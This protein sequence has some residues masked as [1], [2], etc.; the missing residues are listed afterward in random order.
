MDDATVRIRPARQGGPEGQQQDATPRTRTLRVRVLLARLLSC[1][2]I[3]ATAWVWATMEPRA[4]P[5]RDAASEGSAPDA[6]A[7]TTY[8]NAR[9]GTVVEYPAALLRMLP[10]PENDDGR[11]FEGIGQ[12]VFMLVFA[13]HDV[14]D[15]DVR[16]RLTELTGSGGFDSILQIEASE[17]RLFLRGMRDGRMVRLTE[18]HAPD[19]IV[20][21]LDI[22]H[23]PGISDGLDAQFARIERS[24]TVARP[25]PAPTVIDVQATEL[26]FWQSIADSTD[27]ADFHAYLAQWPEGAFALLARNRLDRLDPGAGSAP[28]AGIAPSRDPA[29]YREPPRGSPERAAIMDAARAPV[30]ADLGQHVIF[31]VDRLRSDGN[32]AYLQAVPHQP[33]G[34]PLDWMTTPFAR[35]WQGDFMSDIV[36]VLL[37]RSDGRWQVIDHVVGPTDVY[38]VSWMEDYG[39][40]P[41][42]FSD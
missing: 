42:L 23:D 14:F 32:F 10:P 5:L 11:S 35:E 31:V 15:S 29:A 17:M 30:S 28:S 34:A 4:A 16:A 36:M 27:P 41:A 1:A 12:D 37:R 7:W 22:S 24:F 25:E 26:V 6:L 9:F 19:N 3:A 38:W 21:T 8:Q 39:L 33:G 18:I 2:V 20:H 40:P 13:F